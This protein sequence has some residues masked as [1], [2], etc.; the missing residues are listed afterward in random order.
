MKSILNSISPFLLGLLMLAILALLPIAASGQTS[1]KSANQKGGS[2]QAVS[3]T[4]NELYAALGRND[5]AALDAIYADDYTLVNESGQVTDKAQ[6]LAAIR[7]GD[8]K[9][10]SVGF[11]TP[12]I[13]VHGNTAVAVY[14]ASIKGTMKGK[15]I[16]GNIYVTTAF[17]KIGGKWRLL[18]AH[19]T[20]I[21]E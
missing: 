9:Y 12:A 5:A 4:L 18:A 15:P 20:K 17:V 8:L 16:G 14:K 11:E 1:A 6:R 7:S 21:A 13:R 2:E 10:A 3:K 19:A